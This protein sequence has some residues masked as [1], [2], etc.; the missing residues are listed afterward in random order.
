MNIKNRPVYFPF[1]VHTMTSLDELERR[2]VKI[3]QRNIFV[4]QNKAWETSVTRKILIAL[5]TYLAIAFYFVYTLKSDP[6]LNAVVP[7]VG[8]LLSTLTLP[9]C[10]KL[11]VKF[12]YKHA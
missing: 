11:W 1:F 4:E 12:I 2:V 5:F 3:E 8:F 7:T 6:W 9:Y 10:K